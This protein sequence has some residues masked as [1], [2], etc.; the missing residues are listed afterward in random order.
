VNGVVMMCLINV[1][2]VVEGITSLFQMIWDAI[3]VKIMD[4]VKYVHCL[5]VIVIVMVTHGIALENVEEMILVA[6]AILEMVGIMMN[7]LMDMI[8]W[9]FVV[10]LQ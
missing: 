2:Y 8:A 1:V 6:F 4:W 3:K 10:A 5:M 9:V 7:I